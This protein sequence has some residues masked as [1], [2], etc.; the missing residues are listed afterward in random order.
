[1]DHLQDTLP[2]VWLKIRDHLKNEKKDYISLEEYFSI[3]KSYHL[4][5]E[6]AEY[7]GS[8]LHDL[9]VI[10]HY[11]HDKLL[12]NTVILNPEWA[13]EA[14]YKLIDTRQILENKGRFN[15]ADLKTYWDKTRFPRHKHAEL[16]R[17]MEKFEL[18]FPIEF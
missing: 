4:P 12:E 15:F 11:R 7:L 9:G 18:C 2:G 17:L 3:C 6:R 1:M 10:L 5:E 16:V 13:T 8:Y 14:V